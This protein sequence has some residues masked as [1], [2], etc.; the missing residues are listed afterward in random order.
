[1]NRILV[2]G[3]SGNIGRQVVSQLS[4]TG[5]RI[6]AMTRNPNL[7]EKPSEIEV[8]PG[9]LTK[10]DTL[11]ACLDGV[12]AVFL[13]WIAPPDTVAPV[14]E[15]IAKHARR[16]VFLSAPLKTPH[17]FFQQ[18]N[19]IRNLHIKIEQTIEG[20]GLA[21]TVLRPG[22]LASNPLIWWAAQIRSGA[23]IRWPYL[24]VPTAPTD[25]RDI[26]AVAVKALCE[27]GHAG[28]DY[29]IT[30]PQSLTQREQIETIGRAINRPLRIEEISPD[31]ARSE[32]LAIIQ[33]P[34]I[35]NLL[36]DAWAAGVGLPAFMTS[37]VEELT[38]KPARKFYDWA[39]DHAAAFHA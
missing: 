24:D 3:A 20:S 22:M 13:V 30:G 16:V 35:V 25:E 17:P 28:K 14:I 26:A 7:V 10:P 37:T 6:R 2:I 5:A 8:V 23:T 27:D 4:T 1:M 19:P 15:R 11:E 34:L 29:V 9:D 32:L 36:L 18:P 39:V 31:E 12:D 21:W 38:G 33:P